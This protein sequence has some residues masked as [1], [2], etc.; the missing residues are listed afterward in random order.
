MDIRPLTIRDAEAC[1]S[2]ISTLPYHFGDPDGREACASA[3][4]H[5]PGLA[6]MLDARLVAFVTTTT[7]FGRSAEITWMAVDHAHR[8]R[9]IGRRLVDELARVHSAEGLGSLLVTTLSPTTAEPGIVDGYA[10]TRRF[11][12]GCGFVP[13]WEPSGWWNDHNQALLMQRRLP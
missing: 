4:R 1:D 13:L 10:G 9:G 11:Y 12:E 5:Q 6:A 8:R 2:I 3:V 7:W